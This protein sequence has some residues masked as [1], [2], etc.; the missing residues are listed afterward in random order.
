MW[1]KVGERVLPVAKADTMYEHVP[2][3]IQNQQ[4][5]ESLGK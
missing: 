5:G 1:R 2:T 4:N 3:S